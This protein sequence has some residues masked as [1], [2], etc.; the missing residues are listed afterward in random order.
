MAESSI[1]INREKSYGAFELEAVVK[2]GTD[3]EVFE[4]KLSLDLNITAGTVA[5]TTSLAGVK[6]E[7]KLLALSLTADKG[8]KFEMF[9][10][11][12]Y[13]GAQAK[14]AAMLAHAEVLLTDTQSVLTEIETSVAALQS[15][16]TEASKTKVAVKTG[17]QVVI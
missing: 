10:G 9:N 12:S 8:T 15:S 13:F 4:T 3:L 5:L 17:T 6:I 1:T 2:A 14:A 7:G 11:I 16:V